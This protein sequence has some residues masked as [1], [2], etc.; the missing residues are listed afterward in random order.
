MKGDIIGPHATPIEYHMR[1]WVDN[2][3]VSSIGRAQLVKYVTTPDGRQMIAQS[4]LRPFSHNIEFLQH[5]LESG[6]RTQDSVAQA[7]Q[8]IVIDI[9][10]F[11]SIL[12]RH[13]RFSLQSNK[14]RDLLVLAYESLARGPRS[15]T[16]LIEEWPDW[17]RRT[18]G[19]VEPDGS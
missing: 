8:E 2:C 13:E 19:S 1:R 6:S 10:N 4:M 16:E 7:A 17:K 14:L 5:E 11:L 12:P 9:E 3:R 18:L 15:A